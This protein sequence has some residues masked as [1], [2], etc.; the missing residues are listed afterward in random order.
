MLIFAA[1]LLFT[2]GA[3]HSVVGGKRVIAP[4]LRR[5]DLP[6]ILGS[7]ENTRIT[8]SV[9]WHI[10]TV[11]WWGQ[12]VVLVVVAVAPEHVITAFLLSLSA[13]SALA[14]VLALILS[15]AK[16]LSWIL[17]LPLA[18]ITFYVAIWGDI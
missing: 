4:I 9:G 3:M 2:V 12:A 6:V 5:S 10:L 7:V 1:F 17:F 8:L 18:L 11:F 15:R 14:G 16:H 13:C